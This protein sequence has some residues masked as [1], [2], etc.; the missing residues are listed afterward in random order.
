MNLK[1]KIEQKKAIVGIIGMGYVGVPLALAF[2]KADFIVLGFDIDKEKVYALNSRKDIYIKQYEKEFHS[3]NFKKDH[4]CATSDFSR[5]AQADCILIC[6]PTPL[7]LIGGPDL[8]HVKNTVKSISK[9]IRKDQLIVLESTTYPGTTEEI[10]LPMLIKKNNFEVEEDFFLAFSPE[11]EDPGN[12][13]Y[14]LW[15]TPKVVGGI[16]KK[17]TELAVELYSN[18][19]EKVVV[20]SSP[21]TAEMAKILENTYRCIN[22]ALVNELKIV[23]DKMGIDM[24]EVVDISSTKPF[25]YK[26]FY[27][28]PGFGGHCIPI[29]PFYLSWKAKRIGVNTK[30]IELAG[31]INIKMPKYFLS[32]LERAFSKMGKSI[33]QS[34]ILLIGIAYKK[35]IRDLR[36]SPAIE[37]IRLLTKKGA[38]IKY[39]DPYIPDIGKT[40][41][42]YFNLESQALT[43]ELLMES[44]CAIIVTDHSCYDYEEIVGYSNMVVDTRN[45]TKGIV[46]DKIIK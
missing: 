39:N 13:S 3:K 37:I 24:W 19:T 35:D 44:D 4:F 1:S 12:K 26:P 40:R 21:K 31:D 34:K 28:G 16:G 42:G 29:D 36:E 11:R 27:P 7:N 46:S 9:Y 38:D 33:E 18:I 10:V 32:K 43:K 23:A 25:G 6:V 20:A 5:L 8:S 2:L 45:A 41:K 22:I 15:N 30:F 14:G 17:S